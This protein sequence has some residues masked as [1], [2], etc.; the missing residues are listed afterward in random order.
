MPTKNQKQPATCTT[1]RQ[2]PYKPSH[3][4]RI[5]LPNLGDTCYVNSAIQCLV[6]C[7]SLNLG[8][9]ALMPADA[10]MYGTGRTAA[11]ERVAAHY[12]K[13]IGDLNVGQLNI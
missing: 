5:G 4:S 12:W 10:K 6:H 7:T 8:L 11:S 13:V 2:V 1:K 9:H 3:R